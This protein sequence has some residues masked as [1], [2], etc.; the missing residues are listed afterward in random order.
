MTYLGPLQAV[1]ATT[2]YDKIGLENN[3]CSEE[4]IAMKA[5]C[6][7]MERNAMH[8]SVFCGIIMLVVGLLVG[9]ILGRG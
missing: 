3:K 7:R 6:E 4:I 1:H 9:F 8:N 2:D 5:R